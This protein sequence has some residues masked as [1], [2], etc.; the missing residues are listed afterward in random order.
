VS[1][2]PSSSRAASTIKSVGRAAASRS[3]S[4]GPHPVELADRRRHHRE[5]LRP[6][7]R[8]G[9]VQPPPEPESEVPAQD[10][11]HGELLR[12]DALGQHL[13]DQDGR[14]RPAPAVRAPPS[15]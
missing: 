4:I 7:Q 8:P 12:G 11:D 14:R 9:P 15:P 1:R 6:D 5:V 13:G 3:D 10:C 2:S